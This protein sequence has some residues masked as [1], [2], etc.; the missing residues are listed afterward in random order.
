MQI[1]ISTLENC[2]S[3]LLANG[4]SFEGNQTNADPPDTTGGGGG[5]STPPPEEE[6]PPSEG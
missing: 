1:Q 3:H 4:F 6:E 2:S 5:G